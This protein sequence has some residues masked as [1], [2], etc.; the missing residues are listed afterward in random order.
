MRSVE[1]AIRLPEC[2]CCPGSLSVFLSPRGSA[3][4]PAPAPGSSGNHRE[5]KERKR[6]REKESWL[7]N[8]GVFTYSKLG[9]IRTIT[10]RNFYLP[11]LLYALYNKTFWNFIS[12][13]NET[14]LRVAPRLCCLNF[15]PVGKIFIYR[16]FLPGGCQINLPCRCVRQAIANKENGTRHDTGS[17]SFG[18]FIYYFGK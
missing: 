15:Q 8:V 13:V 12:A 2:V 7:V 11:I 18:F 10:M 9:C 6:E 5:K 16:V 4:L 14:R 1:L 3:K 17:N